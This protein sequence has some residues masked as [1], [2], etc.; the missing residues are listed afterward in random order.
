MQGLARLA[1]ACRRCVAGVAAPPPPPPP[2]HLLPLLRSPGRPC[3][4]ARTCGVH[5]HAVTPSC[6]PLCIGKL[7]PPS[8]ILPAACRTP[9]RRAA[10]S[11][12]L[13]P[14]APT[15]AEQASASAGSIAFQPL[16]ECVHL[17]DFKLP[18][19]LLSRSASCDRGASFFPAL[20]CTP[21]AGSCWTACPPKSRRIGR[22]S[23]HNGVRDPA[24]GKL[25]TA[26][27][28]CGSCGPRRCKI[29]CPHCMIAL[30]TYPLLLCMF[31]PV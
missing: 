15:T 20:P 2:P 29:F 26:R 22:P 30:C 24:A 27:A 17:P 9:A 21:P 14:A 1:D 8:P 6:H 23:S 3:G 16:D 18:C 7:L 19:W 12:A 28:S 25:R 13:A 4:R 5:R 11:T 10:G 31:I